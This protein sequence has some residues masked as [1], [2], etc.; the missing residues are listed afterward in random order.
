V[1]G[2]FF[3][4]TDEISLMAKIRIVLKYA[5]EEPVIQE[6]TFHPILHK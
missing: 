4:S 5:I 6:D 3:L 2:A 1:K